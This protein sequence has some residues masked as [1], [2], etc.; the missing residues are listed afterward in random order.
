MEDLL[1]FYTANKTRL[2][3]P[4][5]EVLDECV[6][7]YA[8]YVKET[9]PEKPDHYMKRL[10]S[11]HAAEERARKNTEA[12]REMVA[13]AKAKAHAMVEKA[14]ENEREAAGKEGEARAKTREVMVALAAAASRAATAPYR[15]AKTA[16]IDDKIAAL[17]ERMKEA[18]KEK[19]P[20]YKVVVLG[21][22]AEE[23]KLKIE[24]AKLVP[25]RKRKAPKSTS[26]DAQRPGSPA[27]SAGSEKAPSDAEV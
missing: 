5:D 26:D 15:K 18:R 12:K 17:K 27:S 23:M 8:S 13:T 1:A 11:A 20:G 7:A 16:E 4:D 24:K 6:R 25:P 22:Q 9:N 14:V 21:L 3:Q 2:E 10:A 19:G